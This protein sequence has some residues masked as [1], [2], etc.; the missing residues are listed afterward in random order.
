M[1]FVRAALNCLKEGLT[2]SIKLSEIVWKFQ[3]P[4][5]LQ[6]FASFSCGW[7]HL[8]QYGEPQESSHA[9]LSLVTSGWMAHL[10]PAFMLFAGNY[11]F[12]R[13]QKGLYSPGETGPK[14][15][16]FVSFFSFFSPAPQICVSHINFAQNG[17]THVVGSKAKSRYCKVKERAE[18]AKGC[19]FSSAESKHNSVK[20]PRMF[21]FPSF[22]SFCAK[23]SRQLAITKKSIWSSWLSCTSSLALLSINV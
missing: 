20:G 22:F 23:K 17:K 10:S 4:Y 1:A 12:T 19:L 2:Q 3:E 15:G 13:E 16:V 8:F 5:G 11:S 21:F 18:L 6:T 7:T 9:P 14:L